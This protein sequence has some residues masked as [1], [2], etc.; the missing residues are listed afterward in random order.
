MILVYGLGAQELISKIQEDYDYPSLPVL[1]TAGFQDSI[2]AHGSPFLYLINLARMEQVRIK[3]L[4]KFVDLPI[5]V[6]NLA[7]ET[8]VLSMVLHG[9][10]V[11]SDDEYSLVKHHLSEAKVLPG[12]SHVIL[13]MVVPLTQSPLRH[14]FNLAW[15]RANAQAHF[16]LTPEGSPWDGRAISAEYERYLSEDRKLTL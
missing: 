12:F 3:S 15:E 13:P 14:N 4:E 6:P 1:D 10:Q 7:V 11:I 2:D 16:T 9:A 5:L 8:R